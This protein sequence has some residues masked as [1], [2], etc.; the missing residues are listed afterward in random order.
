VVDSAGRRVG[1]MAYS[2]EF[3]AAANGPGYL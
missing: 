1:D 3:R 2:V